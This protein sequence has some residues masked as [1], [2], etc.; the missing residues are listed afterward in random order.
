MMTNIWTIHH[1]EEY[2]KDP[3]EF[4]PERF[5]NENGELMEKRE[6][7]NFFAFS[8][9]PR[10]CIGQTFARNEIFLL[11]ANTL[12]NF[13]FE[14]IPNQKLEL[15]GNTKVTHAPKPFYT[16]IVKRR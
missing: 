1:K 7:K 3:L 6:M 10:E 12:Y 2:Y 8:L 14:N 9:G 5:V 15:F 16:K 11:L 4:R 13:K